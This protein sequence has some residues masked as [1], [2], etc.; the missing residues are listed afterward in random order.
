MRFLW[1]IVAL[2]LSLSAAAAAPQV[3]RCGSANGVPT[4]TKPS[5]N[6]CAS[7]TYVGDTSAGPWTWTCKGT[8]N[9]HSA[10]CSAPLLVT[11]PPPTLSLL[12]VPSQPVIPP[13]APIGT[14]VAS[15]VPAWSDG[16][17]FTGT[18]TFA[19]PYGSDS[20]AFTVSNGELLVNA[21]LVGLVGTI[22][23]VTVEA[24]Q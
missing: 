23:Y 9:G 22:Q 12:V 17:R 18:L 3:G 5:S 13:D 16:S 7:G 24:T 1:L 19:S 14:V 8:G 20:G 15:L 10:S 4:A 6:L 11:S 21:S 2:V